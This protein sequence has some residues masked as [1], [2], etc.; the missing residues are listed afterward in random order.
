MADEILYTNNRD[1]GQFQLFRVPAEGGAAV[2]VSPQPLEAADVALAP[3]GQ[4]VVLVSHSGGQPDLYRVDL[5]TGAS[6]RLTDDKA[7]EATPVW[8]PD[9][10]HLVFQ[11]YREARP[12]LYVMDMANGAVRRLTAGDGTAEESLPAVS[13]DGKRVA[14]VVFLG[15]NVSQIR[16]ADLVTG[17]TV[18]LGREPAEGYEGQI[19]WSPSGDRIAYVRMRR[20]TAHVEVMNADGSGSRALTS[21]K[22]MNN[23]PAWSPDGR[24]LLFLSIPEGTSRQAIHAMNADGSQ[25]RE[26][27][28]GAME[29]LQARWSS[30]GKR[31][32]FLR[33]EGGGTRL[34]VAGADGRD[35]KPLDPAP[36]SS[37]ELL[38]RP[39][40][41]S[42]LASMAA[43]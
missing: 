4:S 17:N 19:A 20:G 42:R 13:P 30:D 26:L 40:A 33:F 3:D 7:L 25:Q 32:F 8:T 27:V 16:A 29:H 39:Q 18:V 2:R 12:R 10:K 35:V 6:Q 22:S 31:V 11:S 15:R 41:P 36:G 23:Q 34:F 21:G 1:G 14:H 37:A 43:Q 9:G 24:Q 5:R 28:G 38:V